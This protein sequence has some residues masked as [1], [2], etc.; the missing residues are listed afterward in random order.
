MR[1]QFAALNR[2]FSNNKAGWFGKFLLYRYTVGAIVRLRRRDRW[3]AVMVAGCY[4]VSSNGLR[5]AGVARDAAVVRVFGMWRW[6]RSHA[7]TDTA[8]Q[9]TEVAR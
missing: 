9:V 4:V 6:R 1:A 7:G 5:R 8:W 3:G 2:Y